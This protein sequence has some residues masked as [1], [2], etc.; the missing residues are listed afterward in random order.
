M[1]KI[2]LLSEEVRN[3]IAAGE[4][5]ERPA[6]VVKE[7]VENAVDAGA[8]EIT[9]KIEKGGK[10]L[11]EVSDNGSGIEKDDMR[12]A[13]LAHATSKIVN[14]EDIENIETLGFRGEALATIA[15]IAKVELVSAVEGGEGNKVVCDGENI[16]NVEPAVCGKGTTLTVR[17]VFFNTPVR[18]KFMKTDKK[19][20]ADITNLVTRY[21]LGN[22]FIAFKYYVDGDVVL[23]SYGGGLEEAIAQVYGAKFL[24]NSFRINADRN[25]IKIRGFIGNQNFFKPNK[26]YQSV[27]LN[28]RYIINQVIATA[29]NNAYAAYAMKRNY[30]FYVLFIDVPKDMVDVNVHPNKSDVRFVDNSVVFGSV[31]KVVSSVLDGTAKAAEFVVEE[32]IVPEIKSTFGDKSTINRVYAQETPAPQK[33]YDDD[34]SDVKGIERFQK[35][36]STPETEEKV[37]AESVKALPQTSSEES[38][39]REKSRLFDG[40]KPNADFIFGGR[41]SFSAQSEFAGFN[42]PRRAESVLSVSKAE[43][44]TIDYK[45]CKYRGVLFNTYLLY[46]IGDEVYMIDQHAA[47]ERLI[48]DSLCDK[49]AKR[50]VSMQ[51][52]LTPY[53]LN[54][55][56]AEKTFLDENLELIR[57]IG[58]DIEPWGVSSFRVDSVPADLRNM[59]V[60]EFFDELLSNIESYKQVTLRDMLR[61]KLA[62]T[63]C[64]HA[65]KGGDRLTEEEREKLFKMID[66]NMG[67]K[68]PHGR[69]VCVKLTKIAIEKM[70]KRIV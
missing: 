54:V 55:N 6:S 27:F 57:E 36:Q 42:S 13:F 40:F 9:V 25:D 2:N 20:E 59:E 70:F 24:S 69:P 67:L 62:Q 14:L 18:Y 39:Y 41:E 51:S 63:A 45:A 56:A 35:P 31:Y 5:I 50:E 68:C 11:I 23:Q 38:V 19:E 29:I 26:S 66:G 22:P 47:H 8:T 30:P 48:Y 15:S 65:I 16:G 61:D 53:V 12:A 21:V 34:F 46:E 28:G 44:E 3:R 10:D 52:M 64:K 7:L 4:V 58:F 17:N 60:K 43:Q 37:Q 1:G 49:M 33:V 32:T